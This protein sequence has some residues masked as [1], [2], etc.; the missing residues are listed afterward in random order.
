MN[1][2]IAAA[3]KF[4]IYHTTYFNLLKH[5]ILDLETIEEVKAVYYGIELKDKYKDVIIAISGA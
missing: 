1:G 4:I 5:Q 3:S 2:L